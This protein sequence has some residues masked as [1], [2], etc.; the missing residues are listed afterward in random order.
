MVQSRLEFG[1]FE[2]Q[3]LVTVAKRS[4]GEVCLEKAGRERGGGVISL[5]ALDCSGKEL[6]FSSG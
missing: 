2:D 5:G 3:Q 6:I 4:Q 1:T